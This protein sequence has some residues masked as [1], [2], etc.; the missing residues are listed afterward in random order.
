VRWLQ[1][2]RKDLVEEYEALRQPEQANKFRA[3]LASLK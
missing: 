1:N 3:E 2:A